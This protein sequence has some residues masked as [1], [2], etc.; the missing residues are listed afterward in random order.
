M[1]AESIDKE[2]VY[3]VNFVWLCWWPCGFLEESRRHEEDGNPVHLLRYQ[4]GGRG[5]GV[6]CVWWMN[7][8]E[9]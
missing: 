5:G 7:G 9:I 8:E 1:R 4:D 6:E 2:R 3:S